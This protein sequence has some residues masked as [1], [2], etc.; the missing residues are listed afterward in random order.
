MVRRFVMYGGFST[1]V[2]F[3]GLEGQRYDVPAQSVVMMTSKKV[4]TRL[5]LTDGSAD[6]FIIDVVHSIDEVHT[7]IDEAKKMAFEKAGVGPR[8]LPPDGP[9]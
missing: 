8:Y 9:N 6:S 3:E 2:K 1:W 4:G 7:I 5:K